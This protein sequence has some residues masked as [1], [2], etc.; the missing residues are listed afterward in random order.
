V[1]TAF[2]V[3]LLCLLRFDAIVCMLYSICSMLC[4]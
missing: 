4:V 1:F 2:V 3:V